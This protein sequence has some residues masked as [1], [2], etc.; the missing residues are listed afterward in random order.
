MSTVK[1]SLLSGLVI[2]HPLGGNALDRFERWALTQP[3]LSAVT[4]R[5]R[6]LTYGELDSMAS[7]LAR[8]LVEHQF[9]SRGDR[10]VVCMDRSIEILVGIIAI[11]KAGAVYVPIEP[12]YPVSRLEYLLSDSDPVACLVDG[13]TSA[14][15]PEVGR[16]LTTVVVDA[17]V[18]PRDQPGWT[19][20]DRPSGEDDFYVIYT[21]GTTGAPKGAR[22]CHRN[23]INMQYSWIDLYGL[24][25]GD[26][27]YQTT[28]LGFDVF[29]A[30]WTRTLA[31]GGGATPF[32]AELHA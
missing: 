13:Y 3:T 10:I 28:T 14:T 19:V 25:P 18:Y 5:G 11:L 8:Q 32:F 12:T 24:V 2:D 27:C 1:K 23:I 15:R 20:S 17:D 4:C 22:V 30:D 9:V 26:R 31:D 29:T 16:G 6:S 7:V 21:S